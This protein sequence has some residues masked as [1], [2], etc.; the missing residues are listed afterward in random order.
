MIVNHRRLRQQESKRDNPNRRTVSDSGPSSDD[1]SSEDESSSGSVDDSDSSDEEEEELTKWEQLKYGVLALVGRQVEFNTEVDLS[2]LGTVD[3]FLNDYRHHLDWFGYQEIKQATALGKKFGLS[4]KQMDSFF[5]SFYKLDNTRRGSIGVKQLCLHLSLPRTPLMDWFLGFAPH[6][7]RKRLTVM[8]L[9]LRM[10]LVCTMTIEEILDYQIEIVY[11][12]KGKSHLTFKEIIGELLTL[13][14]GLVHGEQVSLANFVLHSQYFESE[15]EE[16][17]CDVGPLTSSEGRRAMIR[18]LLYF[19]VLV[20]PSIQ[21]HRQLSR[22]FLS[23]KDWNELRPKREELKLN[24]FFT[25]YELEENAPPSFYDEKTGT[26]SAP[27]SPTS[28]KRRVSAFDTQLTKAFSNIAASS[29]RALDRTPTHAERGEFF[30]KKSA[31]LSKTPSFVSPPLS[32]KRD[33]KINPQEG[34]QA[35]DNSQGLTPLEIDVEAPILEPPPAPGRPPPPAPFTKKQSSILDFFTKKKG[36][37]PVAVSEVFSLLENGTNAWTI[38]ATS[39]LCLVCIPEFAKSFSGTQWLRFKNYYS[40]TLEAL[41]SDQALMGLRTG[42]VRPQNL[43]NLGYSY[44]TVSDLKSQPLFASGNKAANKLLVSK[45]KSVDDNDQ[46]KDEDSIGSVK[47]PL[48]LASSSSDSLLKHQKKGVE[49]GVVSD[50]AVVKHELGVLKSLD[51]IIDLKRRK[52]KGEGSTKKLAEQLIPIMRLSGYGD[53]FI[54]FILLVSG[55]LRDEE[56][57]HRLYQVIKDRKEPDDIAF[58]QEFD[59]DLHEREFFYNMRTGEARWDIP[60]ALRLWRLEQERNKKI[61]VH[62]W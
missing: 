13:N 38:S 48:Q 20:Y 34:T 55:F 21:A 19:P 11:I 41:P 15:R 30:P 7:M 60:E 18:C 54:D 28:I 27:V 45:Q 16:M 49:D 52:T 47:N 46:V 59:D 57:M 14:Y 43:R 35:G 44:Y 53:K 26:T 32:L 51:T 56:H 62:I 8:Q 42:Y 2:K 40:F 5:S 9:L 17:G 36:P 29:A 22:R 10:F 23:A 31:D 6:K 12:V 3:V 58:W 25:D 39:L 37:P 50:S 33:A 61:K 1:Y 4:K 24:A